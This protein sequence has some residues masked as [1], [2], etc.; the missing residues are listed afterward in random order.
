M[1]ALS[2]LSSFTSTNSPEAFVTVYCRLPLTV[3][4]LRVNVAMATRCAL[5]AGSRQITSLPTMFFS[6]ELCGV[7]S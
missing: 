3:L 7:W 1:K 4:G 6:I 5:L 2:A